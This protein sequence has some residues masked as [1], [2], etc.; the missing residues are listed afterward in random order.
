MNDRI[1]YFLMGC[2]ALWIFNAPLWAQPGGQGQ[3][4]ET[5]APAS[6]DAES[7]LEGLI[8]RL[9]EP[10]EATSRKTKQTPG[11]EMKIESGHNGLMSVN[12]IDVDIRE[13]LSTLAVEREINI[14]MTKEVSGKISVHLHQAPLQK[15]LGAI[16]LAGGFACQRHKGLYFVYRPKEVW[17]PVAESLEMRVFK[18]RF[19]EMEKISAG[20][21]HSAGKPEQLCDFTGRRSLR[22]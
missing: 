11:T 20:S 6:A 18:L 2:V 22:R 12:F 8:K 7:V 16:T 17:D 14:A 5:G 4:V 21:G 1:G 3:P 9:T 10:Q 13:A 19:A 15:V